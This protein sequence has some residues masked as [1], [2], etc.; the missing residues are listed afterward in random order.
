MCE[1]SF[2]P[3]KDL[4]DYKVGDVKY[5]ALAGATLKHGNA[6]WSTEN[7]ADTT[8]TPEYSFLSGNFLS[9]QDKDTEKYTGWNVTY[10][11]Y[12]NC[13]GDTPA[14]FVFTM[15]GVCD[16]TSKADVW[17]DYTFDGSCAASVTY[18][19]KSGC[20]A[21]NGNA[22]LDAIKPYT[23]VLM[24]LIGGLMTFAGAHFLFQLVSTFVAMI[25]TIVLYLIIS[26]L[27][28]GN[29]TAAWLKV[30]VLLLALAVGSGAFYFSYKF[31]QRFAIPIV[32]GAGGAFGFKLISNVAGVRNEYAAIAVLVAGVVAGVF[33]G[34]KFNFYVKTIGTAFLGAYIFTRG[35]GFFF[36][37][38][39]EAGDVKKM[40]K[41]VKP[42]DKILYY[43]IGFI[44]LFIAGAVVQYKLFHSEIESEKEDDTFTGEDDGEKKC[45][46]F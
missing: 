43:F 45:G 26:N 42:D 44:V 18:T 22:F 15:H 36:G 19:G 14:P 17:S 34:I 5:N 9:V 23:G 38:F 46:C 30:I 8:F 39:P 33:I 40:H 16:E 1:N 20:I 31:G 29:K 41:G 6:Y 32:A 24:I 4:P 37:G 13:G 7:S 28:F 25:T 3:T 12:Q 11:S 2:D 10:A 27:F 21:F 35:A